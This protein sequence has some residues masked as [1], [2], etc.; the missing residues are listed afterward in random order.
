M[1]QQLVALTGSIFIR[2]SLGIPVS[3]ANRCSNWTTGDQP[4]VSAM[5]TTTIGMTGGVQG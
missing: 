3:P 2:A 5:E 4:P 1:R